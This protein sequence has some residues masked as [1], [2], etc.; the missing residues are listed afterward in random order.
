MGKY[1][2]AKVQ[3]NQQKK[4]AFYPHTD[5]RNPLSQRLLSGGRGVFFEWF[6]RFGSLVVLGVVLRLFLCGSRLGFGLQWFGVLQIGFS[7]SIG[8]F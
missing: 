7:V 5:K 2:Y 3:Q 1:P 4:Q 8:C 6:F